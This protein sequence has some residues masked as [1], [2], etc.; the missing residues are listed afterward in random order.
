MMQ[1]LRDELEQ[2]LRD[3][4]PEHRHHRRRLAAPAKHLLPL[5]PRPQSPGPG[6]GSR[7]GRRRLFHRLGL[8]QRLVAN[9]RQ[10][11]SRWAC[12]KDV[13]EGSIRL[14][15][16]PSRPPTRSP[17]RLVV[18]SRLSSTCAQQ[19]SGR[20]RPSAISSIAARNPVEFGLVE[21]A[22]FFG[23]TDARR[24]D[25]FDLDQ[26]PLFA[27]ACP[28]AR[29]SDA[30][31]ARETAHAATAA[32]TFSSAPRTSSSAR[33]REPQSQRIARATIRIVL[34]G[35][36]GVGKSTLAHALA[37]QRRE[38]SAACKNVIATTGADFARALAHAV[39]TES[40]ADFRTRH[41]RCDLLLIDDLHRLAAKPAA[42]QFLARRRSMRSFAAARSCWSRC[43]AAAAVDRGPAARPRQP[44]ERRARSF[45]SR[46]PACWPAASSCARLA[47]RARPA[48][49]RRT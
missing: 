37:A 43:R 4:L 10:H 5:L 2:L 1:S 44:P 34:Y 25:G 22:R 13:I 23:L 45:R 30:A 41:Q 32:S 48:L 15:W 16:G 20:I 33:W 39:E 40:V 11:W 42:Q 18:S 6:D 27:P 17:K 24:G 35:P 36:S 38:R 19:N 8:R 49:E 46:R 14:S 21:S 3:E 26:R 9:P 47:A 12:P 31:R 7:P 29:C 28:T